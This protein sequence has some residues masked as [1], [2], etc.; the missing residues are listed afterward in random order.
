MNT[1]NFIENKVQTLSLDDLKRTHR[2]NDV[3]GRPLK[4]IYHYELIDNVANILLDNG[5]KMQIDEIFAAQNKDRNQA[6]VVILPQVEA[7]LGKNAIEAHVLRRVFSNIRITDF[8]DDEY[9]TNMAIAFHQNGIQIAFGSMVKI[10]HNQCILGA[11]EV[12]SNYGNNKMSIEDMFNTIK[13][14]AQNIEGKVIP[15]RRQY[16]KMKSQ[17]IPPAQILQ[18]IG[19]LQCIRIAHDTGDL[20]IRKQ[21][22]YPM[23]NTQLNKFTEAL[24]IKSVEQNDTV[25]LWDIYNA[26]TE[27][28]KADRMEIP[29]I[30]PQNVAMMDYCKKF[31]V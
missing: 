28:Y 6:G 23:N 1:L 5:L 31:I 19:E 18:M 8:D 29:N 12:L 17:I 16:E 27:M 30:L 9:T 25:S 20:R 2:E 14:W 22:D 3:C 21:G 4:G 26:A 11:S 7:E 13:I 24:M 15:E 10:C